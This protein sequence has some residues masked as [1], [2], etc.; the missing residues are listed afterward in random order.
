M[1][2]KHYQWFKDVICLVLLIGLYFCLTNSNYW[3]A[4]ALMLIAYGLIL[5]AQKKVKGVVLDE[6][7]KV[8]TGEA[9]RQ[10]V[11]G[12]ALLATLIICLLSL[13]P[14][15]KPEYSI[16]FIT[17]IVSIAVIFILQK[18]FYIYYQKF[19]VLEKKKIYIII[20]IIILSM[21]LLGLVRF[22]SGEDDWICQ[23][24]RWVAHGQPESSVPNIEC[25]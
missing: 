25:K 22:F 11:Y 13:S 17:F 10:A 5:I 21:L 18:L 6:R 9:F 15:A 23:N 14:I 7:D 2:L 8:L 1:Q 24:G 3:L 16:I 19:A 12:Y 20:G 4:L